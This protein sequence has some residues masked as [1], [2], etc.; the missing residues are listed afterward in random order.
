MASLEEAKILEDNGPC[1]HRQNCY[2]NGDAS[3][4]YL[5]EG[6]NHHL[7]QNKRAMAL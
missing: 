1:L 3:N 5:K 6:P 2:A 4:F 7:G